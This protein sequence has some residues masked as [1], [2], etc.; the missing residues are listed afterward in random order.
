MLKVALLTA[1]PNEDCL[2]GPHKFAVDEKRPPV[3]LGILYS[4]LKQ[5]KFE[6]EIYDRYCGDER[7]DNKNFKDYDFVGIHCVSVC[8]NDMFNIIDKIECKI[9]AVGGPH[10]YL[11]PDT[12]PDKVTYI[13]RGEAERVICNLVNSSYLGADKGI[14]TTERLTNEQLDNLPRYPYEIFMN[15]PMYIWD[16]SFD[17]ISPVFTLNTSRGCPFNCSFCSVS[18][19]WGRQYTY[20]SSER[21]F[22]DMEYVKLL[23]AKGVYF[24]EDNFTCKESRVR[25]ICEL[26]IKYNLDLKWACETRVDSVN[27]DLMKLMKEAGCIGFYVGVEHLSQKMLNIF[28]KGVTVDQII[29]FFENSHINGIKTAASLIKGHPE[30]TPEDL[31]KQD[32]ILKLIQP[33]M[34]WKNQYRVEG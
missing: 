25:E 14:I 13:V 34:M 11:Y 15:N 24:R 18:K 28:N 1:K 5:N 3:G 31:E 29:T 33:T 27:G 8:T 6:V 30:E 21:V 4:V 17:K 12:F 20:Q 32:R 22:S 7:W 16:F 26:L 10:A 19:I 2:F 9:I 23:G